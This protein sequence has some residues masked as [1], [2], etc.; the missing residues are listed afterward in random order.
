[1]E[2]PITRT[3]SSQQLS[4]VYVVLQTDQPHRFGCVHLP[5]DSQPATDA[6]RYSHLLPGQDG[7]RCSLG[8]VRHP[9][10]SHTG[11]SP[12]CWLFFFCFFLS[13]YLSLSPHSLSLC[14]CLSLCPCLSL[15][16]SLSLS[17]PPSL[18]TLSPS[19]PSSPFLFLLFWCVS[20]THCS[21][22]ISSL[23]KFMPVSLGGSAVTVTPFTPTN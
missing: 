10:S 12:S 17:L 19:L 3:Q 15:F 21:T 7:S 23:G 22:R 1:M 8:R 6:V 4:S 18:P 20:L 16:L 14:L 5:R 2:L 13:F 9:A 11:W